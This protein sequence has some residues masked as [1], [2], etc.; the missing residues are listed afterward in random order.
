M[1]TVGIV[2]AVLVLGGIA[3]FFSGLIKFNAGVSVCRHNEEIDASL[4]DGATAVARSF[5][6]KLVKGDLSAYDALSPELQKVMSRASLEA[7]GKKLI[8]NGLHA[9]LKL[10]HAYEPVVVGT[11]T[12]VLCEP[13]GNNG[14]ISVSALPGAP[15]IHT[16]HSTQTPNNDWALTAWLVQTDGKWRVRGFNADL[17]TMVGYDTAAL[18]RMANAQR[19]KGHAFSAQMLYAAAQSTINRGPDFQLGVGQDLET[20]V[21]AHKPPVEL[22][23]EPPFMW[24][25]D[26]LSF[27][28]EHVSI[29]GIDKKLGL[30]ILHRDP[31]W[32]GEDTGKAERRNKRLI[33]AFVKAHPDYA[34]TFGF[35]VARL[36]KPGETSGWGTVFDAAKGYDT[37]EP[38]AKKKK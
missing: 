38:V 17:S 31:T 33:D 27:A 18:L 10:Q 14:W 8:A 22:T 23:G 34:E 13:L 15:Q 9:D 16:V 3:T 24:R 6:E 28:V 29:L 2:L 36:L 35:L 11:S 26:G 32:D 30:M 20:A 19:D 12:R 21:A 5:F 37:G 4:R 25:Y 1:R 7:G